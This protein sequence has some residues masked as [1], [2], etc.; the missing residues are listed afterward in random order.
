MVR[1]VVHTDNCGQAVQR[2]SNVSGRLIRAE[3]LESIWTT[4]KSTLRANR[5]TNK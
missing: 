5:A 2:A 1:F 3:Y 4:V